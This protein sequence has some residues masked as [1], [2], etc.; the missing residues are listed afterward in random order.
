VGKEEG[1]GNLMHSSFANLRALS[2]ANWICGSH[3][4]DQYLQ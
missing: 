1:K 3:K 2:L 4:V